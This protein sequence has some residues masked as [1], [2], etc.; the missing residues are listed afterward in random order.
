MIL[1]RHLYFTKNEV[2]FLFTFQVK[3]VNACNYSNGAAFSR[4]HRIA[5]NNSGIIMIFPDPFCHQMSQSQKISQ[6]LFHPNTAKCLAINSLTADLIT[7]LLVKRD[8]V[9]PAFYYCF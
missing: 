2:L 8:F 3:A 7:H 9:V 4:S 5:V 6:I 1:I